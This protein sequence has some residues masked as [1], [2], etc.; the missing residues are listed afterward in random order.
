MASL[1]QDCAWIVKSRFMRRPLPN[2]VRVNFNIE[3]GTCSVPVGICRDWNEHD[4]IFRTSWMPCAGYASRSNDVHPDHGCDA[5][6]E[7]RMRGLSSRTT[8]RSRRSSIEQRERRPAMPQAGGSRPHLPRYGV[9]PV[10]PHS[11][12]RRARERGNPRSPEFP[13]VLGPI[14]PMV[15]GDPSRQI[16]DV[17]IGMLASFRVARIERSGPPHLGAPVHRSVNVTAEEVTWPAFFCA[18]ARKVPVTEA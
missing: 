15:H 9:C 12:R 4:F 11:P 10:R 13:H 14:G 2:A 16:H 8:E 18:N 17:V 5:C 1:W 6:A 3:A 7:L